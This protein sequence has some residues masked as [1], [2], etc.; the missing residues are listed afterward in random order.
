MVRLLGKSL[1]YLILYIP[2][3]LWVLVIVPRLFGLPQ[4]G[5]PV[6][7]GLFLL[8]YLLACVQLG[9]VLGN[10]MISRE[11]PMMLLVFSSVILIL[12]SGISW[13]WAAVPPFWKAVGF[14]F[15]STPG[16]QGFVRLNTMAASFHEVADSYLALWV[17]ALLYFGLAY[18]AQRWRN[19][20]VCQD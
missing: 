8:P 18:V 6:A 9:L 10:F 20:R 11:A 13:P 17:Q 2:V 7:I 1:A 15:P 14:L 16:I 4:V 19:S 5:D 12:I 3:C